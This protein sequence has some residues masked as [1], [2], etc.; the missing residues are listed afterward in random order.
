MERKKDI[1]SQTNKLRG[2]MTDGEMKG[3]TT[4]NRRNGWTIN[5]EKK[6]I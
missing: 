4:N 3:E 5:T 6:K 2:R 1:N